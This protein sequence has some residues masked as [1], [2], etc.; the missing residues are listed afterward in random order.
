MFETLLLASTVNTKHA[1]EIQVFSK[2]LK[3]LHCSNVFHC[4]KHLKLQMFKN[5]AINENTTYKNSFPQLFLT[6]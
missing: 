6:F 2:N 5:C 3:T 1:S 4:E